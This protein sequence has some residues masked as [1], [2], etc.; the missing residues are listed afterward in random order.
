MVSFRCA[1]DAVKNVLLQPPGVIGGAC[2]FDV[3]QGHGPA[4]L[5]GFCVKG[6]IGLLLEI[7]DLAP[8]Q[9]GLLGA[10]LGAKKRLGC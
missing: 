4:C 1:I 6:R 10:M 9:R 8:S 7:C 3:D 5:I 2:Q